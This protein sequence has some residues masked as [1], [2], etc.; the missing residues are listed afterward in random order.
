[1]D[2]EEWEEGRRKW[3]R[4][5]R[6]RM[7]KTGTQMR[8]VLLEEEEEEEGEREP[9]VGELWEGGEMFGRSCCRRCMRPFSTCVVCSNE[10]RRV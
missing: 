8:V 2:E 4:V 10:K 9:I 6:R 7:K 1:M 3:M 5:R